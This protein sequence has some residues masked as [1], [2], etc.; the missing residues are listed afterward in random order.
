MTAQHAHDDE[1]SAPPA[2][3]TDTTPERVN[4]DELAAAAGF[5]HA[6]VGP[7]GSC[8]VFLAGQTAMDTEGHIIGT[9]VV[10]QFGH[11]LDNLLTALRATG[12]TPSQLT[13][14]TVYLRDVAAYRRR[15]REIG[16]VWKDRCGRDYPAMAVVGVVRLWDPAALVELQGTAIRC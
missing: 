14:L 1:H 11:A 2:P 7:P 12:S 4:P 3:A 13:S 5:S 6:V 8:P 9:D 16:A 10:E 15:A